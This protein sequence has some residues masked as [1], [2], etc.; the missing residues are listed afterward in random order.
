MSIHKNIC[1]NQCFQSTIHTIGHGLESLVF[2]YILLC[3]DTRCTKK[4]HTC[5]FLLP[6]N[7]YHT[8]AYMK[9]KQKNCWQTGALSQNGLHF[10]PLKTGTRHKRNLNPTWLMNGQ[11]VHFTYC[12]QNTS[13][14]HTTNALNFR[15]D[16]ALIS[17]CLM[18]SSIY[19][20]LN[21]LDVLCVHAH[22]TSL[23]SLMLFLQKH[24]TL[25]YQ[26]YLCC[27]FYILLNIVQQTE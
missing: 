13:A 21:N 18:S 19:E 1:E 2:T 4:A 6:Y 27:I 14:D 16:V 11:N 17:W 5:F 9:F 24:T 7:L 8:G 10:A 22:V 23:L 25:W 15:A 26:I 20:V 12:A 3:I